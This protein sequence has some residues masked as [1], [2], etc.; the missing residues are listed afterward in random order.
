LWHPINTAA[1][2]RAGLRG[3][4]RGPFYLKQT[5]SEVLEGDASFPSPHHP[6]QQDIDQA[7]DPVEQSDADAH[8]E[9]WRVEATT[10][11]NYCE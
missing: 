4:S 11:E 3:D 1:K 9:E 2:L 7:G 6:A 10:D 8:A 5:P